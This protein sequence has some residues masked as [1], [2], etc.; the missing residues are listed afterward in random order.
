MPRLSIE[1]LAFNPR[2][3]PATA[4]ATATVL[5]STEALYHLR[6]QRVSILHRAAK[7][8]NDSSAAGQFLW[9]A[10]KLTGAQQQC[11]AAPEPAKGSKRRCIRD[12]HP[13][14]RSVPRIQPHCVRSQSAEAVVASKHKSMWGSRCRWL[15]DALARRRL[16]PRNG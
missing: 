2:Y 1:Q 4:P 6:A 3:D 15:F 16:P 5:E 10:R 12:D 9:L 13:A 14:R 8:V 7:A 11:L